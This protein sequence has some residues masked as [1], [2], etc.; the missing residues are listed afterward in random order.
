MVQK[1]ARWPTA[2]LT[3]EETGPGVSQDGKYLPPVLA[4]PS[5]RPGRGGP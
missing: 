1:L 3:R 5:A 4:R 2:G